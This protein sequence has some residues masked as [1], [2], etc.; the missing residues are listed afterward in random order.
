M[1]TYFSRRLISLVSICLLLIACTFL[2]TRSVPGDAL[3][4]MLMRSEGVS[5]SSTDYQNRK[6]KLADRLGLDK[7]LFYFSVSTLAE[8]NAYRYFNNSQEKN[9]FY[10]LLNNYGD[11]KSVFNYYDAIKNV[12]TGLT[13]IKDQNEFRTGINAA[14]I[15]LRALKI[16]T[17]QSNIHQQLQL[18]SD[19]LKKISTLSAWPVYLSNKFSLLQQNK[20]GWKKYVPVINFYSNNQFHSWFFG[21][22]NNRGVVSGNLGASYYTGKPVATILK[23]RTGW[24]LLLALTSVLFAYTT[25]I[26]LAAWLVY[27]NKKRL[28]SFF[29]LLVSVFYATPV[30]LLGV[31]LLFMLSNPDVLN[32]LPSSGVKP[33]GG[34]LPGTSLAERIGITFLHLLIPFICYTYATFAFL[35]RTT[36]SLLEEQMKAGYV[37]TAYAK[38][39]HPRTIIFKHALKNAVLPLAAVFTNVFPAILGGSVII[40]TLFSIP[41]I[42]LEIFNAAVSRNYPV[43]AAVFMLTGILTLIGFILSDFITSR[44]DPRISFHKN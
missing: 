22:E 8:A 3:D 23:E 32:V 17:N 24:S 4:Q 28:N 21:D 39:L 25:S 26:P 35:L 38:G 10:Q 14:L 20:K 7:P 6:E 1:G 44:L 19:D 2:L 37:K 33:L 40:E 34:F 11:Y 13:L 27:K 12:E 16:E 18:M 31:A 42:G 41:G 43:I 29:D 30:Y 15:Q 5:V 36:K 9:A